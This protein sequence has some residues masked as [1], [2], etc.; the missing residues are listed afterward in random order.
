VD[1]EGMDD[2]ETIWGRQQ[3][4]PSTEAIVDAPILSLYHPF[5]RDPPLLKCVNL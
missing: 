2:T 5:P 4:S 3:S 1:R